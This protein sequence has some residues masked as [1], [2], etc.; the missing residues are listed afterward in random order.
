[1][2]LISATGKLDSGVG[3]TQRIYGVSQVFAQVRRKERQGKNEESWTMKDREQ[4][5]LR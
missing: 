2:L 3:K 5:R 4:R 1:M